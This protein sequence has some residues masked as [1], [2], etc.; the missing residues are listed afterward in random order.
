MDTGGQERFRSM[1]SSYFRGAHGC[2]LTFSV[3]NEESFNNV[4]HWFHDLNKYSHPAYG[5]HQRTLASLVLGTHSS[6]STSSSSSSSSPSSSTSPSSL[7]TPS[8]RCVSVER[9]FRLAGV[10][11]G[12]GVGG[13]FRNLQVFEVS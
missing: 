8:Q 5:G 1:T 9:A 13:Y 3:T 10:G 2:L 11:V 6:T 12:E 4:I 7:T